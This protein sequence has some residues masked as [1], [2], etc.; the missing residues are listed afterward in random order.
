MR[1]SVALVAV[2]AASLGAASPALAAHVER[3]HASQQASDR[4]QCTRAGVV[5]AECVEHVRAARIA[6]R[7]YQDP[8]AALAD[9][10]VPNECVDGSAE[11]PP[12]EGAMGEHWVNFGRYS[13]SRLSIEEP[14][15]LLYVPAPVGKR[16]A[17]VEWFI[18]EADA[19]GG[20]PRLFGRAFDGPM[21]GHI[22]LQP[23]HY[24]LHVWLWE[25]NPDGLFAHYNPRLSCTPAGLGP[26]PPQSQPPSASSP[27]A[28]ELQVRP[29]TARQGRVTR[30]QFLASSRRE[31]VRRR[32]AGARI[33]FA[34]KVA[35][36]NSRGRATII[37]RFTRP[38]EYRAHVRRRGFR[39]GKTR[40]RV[41][42]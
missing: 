14:E 16:L 17:A 40:V 39:A 30:F 13:D 2:A 26:T 15:I 37:Q 35:Y 32:V 20:S 42:R 33:R 10:F 36:T 23:R 41:V 6:T 38:G 21:D 7:K 27:P 4:K 24:D 9:G 31:G 25:H 34:R 18:P 5:V 12:Q 22:P 19:A 11:S 8:A 28:L 1:K 29:Q 3:K